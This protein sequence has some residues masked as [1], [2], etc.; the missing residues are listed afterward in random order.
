MEE[1]RHK[2]DAANKIQNIFHMRKAIKY[3]EQKRIHRV[4]EGSQSCFLIWP[5]SQRYTQYLTLLHM[6]HPL[7]MTPLFMTHLLT[8]HIV[9]APFPTPTNLPFK[10]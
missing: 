2:H 9:A 5:I 7:F 3:V 4:L 10:K 6:I 8:Y 1:N